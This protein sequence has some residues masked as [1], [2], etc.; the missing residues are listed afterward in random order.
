MALSKEKK[1]SFEQ[2][3]STGGE[4]AV[5]E[6]AAPQDTA[7]SKPQADAGA[8]ATTAIAMASA[9]SLSVA[10]ASS[11]AKQFAKEVDDMKGAAD[12]SYGNYDVYKGNNGEIVQSGSDGESLGRWAKVRMLAWGEHFEVSPGSQDASSKDFVAYSDDGKAIA[13]VIGE[14]QRSWVG[15]P[16]SEYIQYLRT[17]EDFEGADSRRFIDISCALLAADNVDAPIGTVIQVTLSQSSI[18]AFSKYQED[19]KNRARCVSMGLPGFTLPED[20]F[21]FHFIREL[22]SKGSNK[23]TKLRIESTL[24][25]KL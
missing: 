22:A 25:N 4:T 11:R 17:E 1:P 18:P 3:P 12:F 8:A 19:L 5:Q 6:R 13:S 21:T 24:P 10:E 23:W 20:P 2:E 15:K 14:E 9:T 16:V 7:D